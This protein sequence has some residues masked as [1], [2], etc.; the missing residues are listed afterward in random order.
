MKFGNLVEIFVGPHL[1]VKGLNMNVLQTR[2]F[3][4]LLHSQKL[5]LLT[6]LIFGLFKDQND[7]FSYR[8]VFLNKGNPNIFTYLKPLKGTPLVGGGASPY[9]P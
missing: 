9:R 1:T 5:H 2:K 4:R 6:L 8:F 3:S 7:T